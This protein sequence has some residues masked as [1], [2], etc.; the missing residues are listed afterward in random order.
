MTLYDFWNN[1]LFY[2]KMYIYLT[3]AYDQNMPLFKGSRTDWMEKECADGDSDLYWH[4][5][6]TVE[7]WQVTPKGNILVKLRNEDYEKR[8]EDLYLFSDKWTDKN[9]PWKYSIETEIYTEDE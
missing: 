3:N 9:R 6:D 7:H 2:Q 5:S 1:T 4:L 8:M